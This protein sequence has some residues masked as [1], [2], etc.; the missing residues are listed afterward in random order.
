MTPDFVYYIPYCLP[1]GDF[2]HTLTGI[3]ILCL[4]LGLAALAIFQY[5]IKYPVL[6]LLPI[7]HQSRLYGVSGDFTFFP[8]NQFLRIVVSILVGAFTHTIWDSFTHRAGWVVNFFVFLKTP[9]FV[10][11]GSSIPIYK[12]MQH[13]ST[14]LGIALLIYWYVEWYRKAKTVTIP[15]EFMVPNRT[16]IAV[17]SI[18][19]LI[20]AIIATITAFTTGD[21]P[22]TS[23]DHLD[24]F[25]IGYIVLVSVF[26]VEL[27]LLGVYQQI[28]KHRFIKNSNTRF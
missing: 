21:F 14:L 26:T 23:L 19:G 22:Q 4:P 9:A 17:F 24:F 7:N 10:I 8:F 20:A 16:K 28:R 2:C 12:L 5:L 3:F 27:I 18:M 13:G 1:L 6:A 11:G 25:I 15:D